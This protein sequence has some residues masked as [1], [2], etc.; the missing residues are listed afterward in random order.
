MRLRNV[1]EAAAVAVA[2]LPGLAGA[3]TFTGSWSITEINSN[4]PGLLVEGNPIA[5]TFSV[6]L[7][8]GESRTFDLFRIWTAEH[9]GNFQDQIENDVAKPISVSFAFSDPIAS[10]SVSGETKAD[11]DDVDGSIP[12][13]FRMGRLTWNGPLVLPFGENNSGQLTL[14]LLD[15]T[16]NLGNGRLDRGPER[17]RTVTAT[18]TYDAAPQVAPVP[19]PAALPMLVGGLGIFGLVARRRREAVSA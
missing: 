17:G 11:W 18:L 19:L 13:F 5:S 16:F 2:S 4:G 14:A 15:A 8:V 6:D 3:A 9:E 12:N 1:L 7:E 10:G